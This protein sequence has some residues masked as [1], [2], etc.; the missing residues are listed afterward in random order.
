MKRERRIYELVSE[1][2]FFGFLLLV[3]H[4]FLIYNISYKINTILCTQ[5]LGIW[6]NNF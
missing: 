1:L 2:N 6:S 3:D 4:V 5:F